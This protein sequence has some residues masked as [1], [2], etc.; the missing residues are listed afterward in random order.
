MID[1][2]FKDCSFFIL[3]KS[4]TLE[5]KYRPNTMLRLKYN[6]TAN[7]QHIG[8]ILP[9]NYCFIDCDTK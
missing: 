5:N 1:D 2:L 8:L 9:T 7:Y 4:K 3:Y 6:D